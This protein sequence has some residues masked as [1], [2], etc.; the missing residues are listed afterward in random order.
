MVLGDD[1]PRALAA[2]RLKRLARI[3]VK[4]RRRHAQ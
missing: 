4:R 1:T 2:D 3:L